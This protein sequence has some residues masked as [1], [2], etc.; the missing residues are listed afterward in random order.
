MPFDFQSVEN[1]KIIPVDNS[2]SRKIDWVTRD[3]G[4]FPGLFL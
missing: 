2:L 1:Q 4:F 3:T